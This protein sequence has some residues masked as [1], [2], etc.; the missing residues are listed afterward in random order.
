MT[1]T[2]R[3]V[4]GV[5]L[6]AGGNE[7]YPPVAAMDS[8]TSMK[9]VMT[10][11]C[12]TVTIVLSTVSGRAWATVATASPN[13]LRRSVT[14]AIKRTTTAVPPAVRKRTSCRW[15]A[16]KSVATESLNHRKNVMMV[17]STGNTATPVTPVAPSPSSAAPATL[18]VWPAT[19]A[20]ITSA[21]PAPKTPNV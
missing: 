12:R 17:P 1:A 14:M 2:C 4:T 16:G 6:S 15:P 18:S 11:T 13:T 20:S 19:S 21:P 9:S 10:V 8:S 5:P 3:M 7:P